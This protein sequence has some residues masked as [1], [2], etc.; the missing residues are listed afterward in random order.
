[1]NSKSFVLLFIINALLSTV[2]AF[3]HHHSTSSR[4]NQ[5]TTTLLHSA[6]SSTLNK[7]YFAEYSQTT[8]LPPAPSHDK[9]KPGHGKTAIIAGATGYIGRAVVR[10]CV[11]RGYHTVSLVRNVTS[12]SFDEAL[13]GSSLVRCNVTND[14]EVHSIVAEIAAGRHLLAFPPANNDNR[15]T[16]S[17]SAPPIDLLVSCLAS[18]SGIESSVYSIDYAATLSLLHAGR[19]QNARHFVLLSAYCCRNP[20][21]KLQQAKLQFESQLS[22][23]T[24]MTYSIVRPTAFF[25][26]VSG[27]FESIVAG[28]SYVLFG[29][30]EVTRC[31][32]I[33]EEDLAVYMCDCALEEFAEERW[34]R[35]LN[36]GGPDGPLTNRMLGEMMFRA[37]NKP[38]KFVYVP[39]QIFDMSISLIEFIAKNFP[40]QKW[41][42]A[43]ETAKIGK[44]YAVEDML[45]TNKS[46]KFGRIRM[47][48]HFEKIA[49]EG[50]DPFTPVRATAFISK[51][52]E[53]LPVVSVSIPIG[54]G[55]AS[56][57]D[58]VENVVASSPLANVPLLV[59][60]LLG[61]ENGGHLF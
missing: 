13:A 45:T 31:N 44:Y 4:Q 26:S 27:Q 29:D 32:P 61:G 40:S 6:A 1:M 52:L 43:L 17:S 57:P 38:P 33:S 20:L 39:T 14:A 7:P 18:P 8:Q 30:G 50:Q 41:E 60:S 15:A 11:S 46:E 3:T 47:M 21:L 2:T 51:T 56:K 55:L 49:R 58:I 5:A 10:E 36:V 23:Q 22:T 19:R 25:K 28:N 59:A 34:G 42:D 53:T 9:S 24:D 48:D 35:V 12:A 16:S 37:I 54:F